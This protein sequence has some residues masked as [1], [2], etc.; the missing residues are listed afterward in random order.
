M[1]LGFDIFLS[2]TPPPAV[3]SKCLNF[4]LFSCNAFIL[5]ILKYFD[6][7]R[8]GGDFYRVDLLKFI[9]SLSHLSIPEYKV[10]YSLLK[11]T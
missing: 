4:S 2:I 10:F 3:W 11:I 5:A 1:K 7:P 8:G 9:A 6:F